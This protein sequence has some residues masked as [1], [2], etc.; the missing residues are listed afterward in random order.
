MIARLVK[1]FNI[2]AGEKIAAFIVY[3]S[4]ISVRL[5]YHAFSPYRGLA[6]PGTRPRARRKAPRVVRHRARPLH[7]RGARSYG[8]AVA[9]KGCFSF[10]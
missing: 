2:S 10:G 3:L 1:S 8:T 9:L 6:A 4:L 5:V 7:H